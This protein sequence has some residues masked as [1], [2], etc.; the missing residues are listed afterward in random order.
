MPPSGGAP[1]GHHTRFGG[2]W[3]DGGP[4]D[5]LPALLCTFAMAVGLRVYDW[6]KARLL[7]GRKRGAEA[8]ERQIQQ[9]QLQ[10][11]AREI[12]PARLRPRGVIDA[13]GVPFA[14]YVKRLIREDMERS[15][16]NLAGT[17]VRPRSSAGTFSMPR[18]P[19]IM[20]CRATRNR[21]RVL[22]APC[23][24]RGADIDYSLPAGHPMNFE[25]DEVVPV[26]HKW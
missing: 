22:G 17:K 11:E 18:A 5:G 9:G 13:N 20:S 3:Q 7:D 15:R 8:R 23:A 26:S 6:A 14:T 16:G 24:I 19:E 12:L 2:R 1:Q 25:V 10:T 21:W 4:H